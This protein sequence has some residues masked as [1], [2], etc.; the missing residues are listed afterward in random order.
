M[1]TKRNHGYSYR[2][3]RCTNLLPLTH[4]PQKIFEASFAIHGICFPFVWQSFQAL[5]WVKCEEHPLRARA[6]ISLH[7]EG[8]FVVLDPFADLTS[9][10]LN[11]SDV[12]GLTTITISAKVFRSCCHG[13]ALPYTVSTKGKLAWQRILAVVFSSL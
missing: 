4:G 2:E 7:L 11:I 3:R 9:K 13:L 5:Y 6:S 12:T 1:S 10:A 8:P